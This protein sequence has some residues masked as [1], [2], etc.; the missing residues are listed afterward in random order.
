MYLLKQLLGPDWL[1]RKGAKVVT[2]NKN[3]MADFEDT[4]KTIMQTNALFTL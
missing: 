4:V 3:K 2:K 1:R